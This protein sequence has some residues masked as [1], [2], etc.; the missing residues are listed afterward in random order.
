MA[1]SLEIVQQ[2]AT[3]QG[4]LKAAGKLLQPSKWPLVGFDED[5]GLVWGE[6][7]GSSSTPYRVV[8]DL[9]DHGYKCTCPSRKFPCK[10]TLAL[11]WRHAETGLPVGSVP[12]WVE[13]WLTRRRRRAPTG[14]PAK[15]GAAPPSATKDLQAALEPE[16]PT[17]SPEEAAAKAE[18][19][20][21]AA[22]RRREK[23]E[24]K[25]LEGLAELERWVG[26]VLA[27]GTGRFADQALDRC[28]QVAARLV[29]AQCGGLARR[30]DEL[31]SRLFEQPDR[32]RTDWLVDELGRIVLLVH[33]YRRQDQLSQGLRADVRR[34]VG[35]DQKRQELLDDARALRVRDVWTV[36]GVHS[37]T[38]VDDLVR[39]ETWLSRHSGP[40]WAV[41]VDYAPVRGGSAAPF[42]RGEVLEAELVY[43]PSAVPLRAL[44]A[45]RTG[46][47]PEAPPE[48]ALNAGHPDI[49]AG[50]AHVQALRAA[51]PWLHT[52]PLVLERVRLARRGERLV[53]AGDGGP[54]PF[55]SLTPGER[56]ERL[57][58]GAAGPAT[59][60]GLLHG[61]VFEP[62]A[63]RTSL[64]WWCP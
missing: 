14:R 28:R 37:E 11:A 47:P 22:R 10:H 18:R 56:E 9:Q 62:L 4:S 43:Y 52:V 8:F 13:E 45:Q 21:K 53:L 55:L 3:D 50:W 63:A 60:A 61:E 35:W 12:E 33:A 32:E 6:C 17:E 1:L 25:M 5:R 19:A 29:D 23:R 49:E 38:Q 64:G 31:P 16:A 44:L 27:E 15:P 39:H 36:L 46:D 34:M 20:A 58:L 40:E 59:M 26:D 57:A 41:L 48:A 51:L 24:A 54:G 7:Q 42:A 30:L 2:L